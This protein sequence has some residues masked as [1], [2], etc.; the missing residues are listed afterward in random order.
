MH[1]VCTLVVNNRKNLSRILHLGHMY[2]VYCMH[3]SRDTRG[4]NARSQKQMDN[5]S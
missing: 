5:R 1:N 3:D 4:Q 2:L